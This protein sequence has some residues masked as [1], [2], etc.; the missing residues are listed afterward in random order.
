MLRIKIIM[1]SCFVGNSIYGQSD[2]D[3]PADL[4]KAAQIDSC[5]IKCDAANYPQ[6]YYFDKDGRIRS[7]SFPTSY[8]SE[9]DS[10]VYGIYITTYYYNTNGRLFK[11]TEKANFES[12]SINM[13]EILT[14]RLIYDLDN[15]LITHLYYFSFLS[16]ILT[17]EY[18]N[19]QLISETAY[20]LNESSGSKQAKTQASK[21]LYINNKL[22][23]TSKW[24]RYDNEGN[25]QDSLV[26]IIDSS[27]YKKTSYYY[28][29]KK[30]R[31][32]RKSPEKYIYLFNSQ[33][34]IKEI[35]HEYEDSQSTD[36]FYRTE[37]GLITKIEHRGIESYEF[38]FE[39][40]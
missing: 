22:S 13:P 34:K 20:S 36:K 6:K 31:I 28:N 40:K 23:N 27:H 4:I 32:V 2:S 16:K 11:K 18:E 35:I 38:I 5:I 17:Y 10:V 26:T 3:F 21:T 8:H 12:D 30:N 25:T 33:W 29:F 39:Y 19:D 1:I 24:I 7:H 37:T 15:K 9:N 14:E